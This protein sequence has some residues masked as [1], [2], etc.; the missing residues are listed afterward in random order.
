MNDFKKHLTKEAIEDIRKEMDSVPTLKYLK[1]FED[2]LYKAVGVPE[3][4]VDPQNGNLHTRMSGEETF[5]KRMNQMFNDNRA[6][7]ADPIG[8]TGLGSNLGEYTDAN[9]AYANSSRRGAI[10]EAIRTMDEEDLWSDVLNRYGRVITK[11]QLDRILDAVHQ[12]S[13]DIDQGSEVMLDYDTN[14]M[15]GSLER[16]I[17][18]IQNAKSVKRVNVIHEDF[19]H[20]AT[21]TIRRDIR[22]L[23]EDEVVEDIKMINSIITQFKPENLQDL[24]VIYHNVEVY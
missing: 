3:E 23:N 18:L 1:E 11:R 12:N 24:E 4:Y 9:N 22:R 2:K 8:D 20:S 6:I 17:E 19:P 15:E 13:D 16:M 14:T 5:I 10:R 21:I 7:V